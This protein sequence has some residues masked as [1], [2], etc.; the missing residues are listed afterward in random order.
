[1]LAVW[2]QH[3]P[4]TDVAL[5]MGMMRI[6]V[7]EGLHDRA[8]IEARCENF[9][10]FKKSLQDFDLDFVEQ[11]TKVPRDKLVDAARMLLPTV[12]PAS[13]IQWVLLNI[14]MAPTML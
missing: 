9:D 8:F 5:L 12:L 11:V 7:D 1:M 4:G 3:S 13:S 14:L 2:L 10:E 6:V